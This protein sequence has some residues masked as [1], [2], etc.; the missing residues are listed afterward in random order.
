M[1][2]VMVAVGKVVREFIFWTRLVE[3]TD[4]IISLPYS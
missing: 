1:R 4:P 3:L 2:E